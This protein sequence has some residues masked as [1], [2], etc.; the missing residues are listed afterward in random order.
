MNP[1]TSKFGIFEYDGQDWNAKTPV[2]EITSGGAPTSSGTSGDYLV[3]IVNGAT[4]TEIE[5]Y[6]HD[7]AGWNP[8]T[9]DITFAPHYAVPATSMWVKTT[10]PGGGL[11][12]DAR[13][14]TTSAGSFVEQQI[15]YA[16]DFDPTGAASDILHDGSANSGR[17]LLEGDLALIVDAVNGKIVFKRW[18]SVQNEWDMVGTD[19]S[20]STGG[21]IMN[22]A[23]AMP[24]GNPANGTY[25]FDDAQ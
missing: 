20:A 2:V 16:Q 12:L 10:T 23:T 6:K 5:Y 17:T 11:D 8:I 18:D 19:A 15:L 7:G 13:L 24:V 25:W 3:A 22:V 14:Y 9:A 1:S 21:Y 4:E